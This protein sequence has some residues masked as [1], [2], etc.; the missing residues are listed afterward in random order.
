M[1]ATMLRGVMLDSKLLPMRGL[2]PE[3]LAEPTVAH[4]GFIP[5]SIAVAPLAPEREDH[6]DLCHHLYGFTV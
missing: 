4:P 6:I 5:Q 2:A 3:P 1:K